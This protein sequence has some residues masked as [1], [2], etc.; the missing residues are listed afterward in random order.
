MLGG[1]YFVYDVV[2]LMSVR[3]SGCLASRDLSS[4]E[5]SDWVLLALVE[6][7]AGYSLARKSNS[8]D[9]SWFWTVRASIP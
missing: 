8:E 3:R 4:V 1:V 6:A 9:A 2:P 5:G 7:A